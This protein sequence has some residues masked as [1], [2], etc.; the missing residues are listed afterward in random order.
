MTELRDRVVI[1]FGA[2]GG[3]GRTIV[4]DLAGA[5]AKLALADMNPAA[6]DEVATLAQASVGP[7]PA[8]ALDCTQEDQVAAF[9][10]AVKAQ[11]GGAD[12]LI[13]LPGLSIPAKIES[14]A[15]EDYDKIFDINVKGAFLAAK[16][17][18]AMADAARGGQIL[19]ISSMASK[20]A[21]PNAP[22]YCA[23]KAAVSMLAQ[24]LALQAKDKSVR[25]T[26]LLPGPTNTSGFWG[27]RPVPREKFMTTDDIAGM[28][29]FIL[30]LPEHIVMHEVDFESFV[31][32]KQ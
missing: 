6:L 23:A 31:Y 25:V 32:F 15:V 22:V 2:A 19:L 8:K 28:V 12:A 30:A 18:L 1:V 16:H 5:G 10:A 9:L 4:A 26:T 29:H 20:R 14:M 7:V 13:Y 27:T 11:Y 17:F 3:M 21:N 24:G